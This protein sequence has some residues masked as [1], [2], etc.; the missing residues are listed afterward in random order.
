[1]LS[2]D[3]HATEGTAHINGYDVTTEMAQARYH[4]GYCP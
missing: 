2:G 4:I 1:M 3:I